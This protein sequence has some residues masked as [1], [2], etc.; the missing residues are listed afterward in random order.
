MKALTGKIN[1]LAAAGLLT[2]AVMA[3]DAWAVDLRKNTV[4]GGGG[5]S[6]AADYQIAGTIGQPDAAASHSG[7]AYRIGGGYWAGGGGG[8]GCDT[9]APRIAQ[10]QGL[11]GFTG[12]IDPRSESSDG[13]ALDKGIDR[14]ILLFTEPVYKI[15]GGDLDAADFE[16]LE[17]GGGAAPAVTAV[18]SENNPQIKVVFDRVITLREWTTIV[19]H[20]QDDCGNLILSDGDLGPG[21]FEQDRLDIA[22]L[23]GDIDQNSVVNPLD[24]LRFRQ[25]L[26]GNYDPPQ[27]NDQLYFDTDR[28]NGINPLDLLRFRQLLLGTGDATQAWAGESMNTPQP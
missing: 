6:S 4:D 18:S 20:V 14:I 23:P 16:L 25:Y 12:Y 19:A 13:T 9:L 24:L 21:A 5:R 8:G 15:G 22:F 28:A 27:G 26:N 17:T 2:A 7:G 1:C 11:P 10:G 3:N